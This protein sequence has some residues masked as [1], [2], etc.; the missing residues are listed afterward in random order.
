MLQRDT[1][2]ILKLDEG[3][4]EPDDSLANKSTEIS[5]KSKVHEL[6]DD[7]VRGTRTQPLICVGCSVHYW[8]SCAINNGGTFAVRN[9]YVQNMP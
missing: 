7:C 5:E 8:V 6:A 1:S 4:I 3:V 2:F 9:P